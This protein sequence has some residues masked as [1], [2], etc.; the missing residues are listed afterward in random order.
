MTLRINGEIVQLAEGATQQADTTYSMDL[1]GI[2]TAELRLTELDQADPLGRFRLRVRDGEL[3]FERSIEA[4]WADSEV[5]LTI[6]TAGVDSVNWSDEGLIELLELFE[7]AV[8]A[9]GDVG[10]AVKKFMS[11]ALLAVG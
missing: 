4:D 1:Q 3:V 7:L 10:L 11:Y 5:M 2:A 8:R 9:D 6:G